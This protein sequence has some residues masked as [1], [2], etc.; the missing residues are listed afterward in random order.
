MTPGLRQTTQTT[1]GCWPQW[2]LPSRLLLFSSH[3]VSRGL[4]RSPLSLPHPMH[5]SVL[6]HSK[7]ID[8]ACVR[9][10]EKEVM[11]KEAT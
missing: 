7:T 4:T 1:P 2:R 11:D 9:H 8:A 6:V 3:A 10:L 5:P